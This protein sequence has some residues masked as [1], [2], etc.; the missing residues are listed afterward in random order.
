MLEG[1]KGGRYRHAMLSPGLLTAAGLGGNRRQG[2]VALSA[3]RMQ[4][5]LRG[6]KLRLVR[7][8]DHRF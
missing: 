3:V 5:P 4:M 6:A 8:S 2:V 1:G 7:K